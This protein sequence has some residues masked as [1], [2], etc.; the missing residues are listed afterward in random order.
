MYLV[1]EDRRL[2]CGMTI[3]L[4]LASYSI[5]RLG[6][7][8]TIRRGSIVL[9]I[10]TRLRISAFQDQVSPWALNYCHSGNQNSITICILRL[11]KFQHHKYTT[12]YTS[13]NT[14]FWGNKV[15]QISNANS[16][17]WT[18]GGIG[19]SVDIPS[20]NTSFQSNVVLQISNTNTPLSLPREESEWMFTHF[21]NFYICQ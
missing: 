9:Y 4:G 16:L 2:Y 21:H 6:V 14:S 5:L 19:T 3:I 8:P 13:M 15:L 11:Y 1:W 10:V 17:L 12:L 18:L 7:N 20:T